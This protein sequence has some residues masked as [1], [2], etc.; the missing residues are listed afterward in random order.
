MTRQ[1]YTQQVLSCL[2]RLTEAERSA[3]QAEL[4]AHME[5]HMLALMDLGYEE[6]LAEERML[7]HMGDP[8]EV[9]RELDRQYSTFW[10]VV[11]RAATVCLALLA[12]LALTGTFNTYYLFNSIRARVAPWSDIQQE[13]EEAVNQQLD[14]RQ[15]VGSDILRILGSGTKIEEDEAVAVVVYCQYDQSPFGLVSDR[16]IGWL[17]CRGEEAIGGGGGHSTSAAAYSRR[18]LVVQAGDPYVTAVWE[19]YGE[20]VELQVPLEWE[21]AYE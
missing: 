1:T 12:A 18:E 8:A 17:D 14:I 4:E 2:R 3:V 11:S 13:W 7:Q 16:N 15:P 5:D 19:R 9:G 20:R 10:L 21:D 6:E